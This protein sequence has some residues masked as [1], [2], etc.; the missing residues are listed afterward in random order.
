M[1]NDG[2]LGPGVAASRS[3]RRV[4]GA[5]RMPHYL[6]H[7]RDGPPTRGRP[8]PTGYRLQL[9]TGCSRTRHFASVATGTNSSLRTTIIARWSLA[10]R[11]IKAQNLPYRPCAKRCGSKVGYIQ[12]A[13]GSKCHARRYGKTRD[14]FFKCPRRSDPHHLARV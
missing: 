14:D 10:R 9:M 6:H 1:A 13:V 8:V 4:G 11:N 5:S 3:G 2:P 12:S 7:L